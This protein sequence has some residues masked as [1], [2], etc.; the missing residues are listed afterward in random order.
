MKYS[1]LFEFDKNGKYIRQ[2]SSLGQGPGEYIV[3]E[4]FCINKKK[5]E[6]YLLDLHKKILAYDIDTGKYLRTINYKLDMSS[7]H[8]ITFFILCVG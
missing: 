7:S 6:I 3:L 8:Y 2:I 4:E 1:S 5:R